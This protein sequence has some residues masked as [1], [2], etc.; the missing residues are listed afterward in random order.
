MALHRLATPSLALPVWVVL[1]YVAPAVFGVICASLVF[2][3]LLLCCV[4]VLHERVRKVLRPWAVF[5]VEKGLVWN[6]AAQRLE[7]PWLTAA[8]DISSASVSV[9]FYVCCT[10]GHT[11]D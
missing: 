3:F 8:F 6:Q 11:M 9:P 10:L 1:Q 5:H 7:T 2:L 4:P